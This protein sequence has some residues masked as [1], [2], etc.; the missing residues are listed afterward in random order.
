M[1]TVPLTAYRTKIR[2]RCCSCPPTKGWMRFL[3][4]H[5]SGSSPSGNN[6]IGGALKTGWCQTKTAL[7]PAPFWCTYAWNRPTSTGAGGSD[8]LWLCWRGKPWFA[9]RWQGYAASKWSQL[10]RRLNFRPAAITYRDIAPSA[11]P[12]ASRLALTAAEKIPPVGG[13]TGLRGQ[14][15]RSCCG[16]QVN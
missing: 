10:E 8:P 16:D 2:P 11:L 13:P 9:I 5:Y 14:G 1:Q 6:Q 15:A 4:G 3:V 7:L 12:I